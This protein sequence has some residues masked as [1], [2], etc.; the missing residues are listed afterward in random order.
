VLHETR[1]I[2]ALSFLMLTGNGKETVMETLRKRKQKRQRNGG[3]GKDAKKKRKG[4]GKQTVETKQKRQGNSD[5]LETRKER[6]KRKRISDE[7]NMKTRNRNVTDMEQKRFKQN[8][9]ETLTTFWQHYIYVYLYIR[10]YIFPGNN[11]TI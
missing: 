5:T 6:W 1:V 3:N 4:N 2:V 8:D 9:K 11:N 10:F 7:Q